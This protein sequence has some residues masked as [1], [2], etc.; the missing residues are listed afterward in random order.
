MKY[1]FTFISFTLLI[2]SKYL[3]YKNLKENYSVSYENIWEEKVMEKNTFFFIKENKS[4][5]KT[6]INLMTQNLSRQP[7][8]LNQYHKITL[9]QIE[10]NIGKSSILSQRD[11]KVSNING[12]ELIYIIPKSV[13]NEYELKIKQV[14]F[15]ERNKAFLLTFVSS[16]RD[17]DYYL[18]SANILFKSFKIISD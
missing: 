4:D 7:L 13:N 10:T 15:V 5:F 16:T 17:Y 2:Q 14:Y 12:K 6:N 1:L 11:I 8:S 18:Q 9:N 3:T